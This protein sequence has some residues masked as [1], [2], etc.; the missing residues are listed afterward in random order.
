MSFWWFGITS[1]LLIS[2][3][4]EESIPW[5]SWLRHLH[6]ISSGLQFLDQVGHQDLELPSKIGW[7]VRQ[8]WFEGLVTIC[9]SR[10]QGRFFQ[11]YRYLDGRFWFWKEP[12]E[13][14][15]DTHQEGRVHRRTFL[16]RME[17]RLGQQSWQRNV[18]NFAHLVQ[19]RFL[20][21]GLRQV[22]MF[23]WEFLVG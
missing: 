14:P 3:H 22:F 6:L 1:V 7:K 19:R 11:A 2:W 16:P 9:S 17:S 21:L 15:L 23:P 18:W 8:L 4:I 13:Q 5:L 12:L 10:Y 20:Q